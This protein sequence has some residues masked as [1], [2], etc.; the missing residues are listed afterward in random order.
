[1]QH[2]VSHR[3][4][5]RRHRP[6]ARRQ[7]GRR[8]QSGHVVTDV[9][10]LGLE[11]FAPVGHA[12]NQPNT[13]NGDPT[14]SAQ[15]LAQFIDRIERLEDEKKD[16]AADIREVYAE[17]KS[18]GFDTKIMRRTIRERKIPADQRKEID[19]HT[20]LYM[21]AVDRSMKFKAAPNFKTTSEPQ[22]V[23]GAQAAPP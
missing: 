18:A 20:K 16:L 3:T 4:A 14:V 22:N 6:L 21:E 1:M 7:F 13:Q 17:A 2:G 9:A 8:H 10:R 5:A 23:S 19:S 15:R 12:M 11:V